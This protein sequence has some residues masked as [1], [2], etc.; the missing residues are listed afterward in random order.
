[1]HACMHAY[2]YAWMHACV[3][4]YMGSNLLA[5]AT[6]IQNTRIVADIPDAEDA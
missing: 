6:D 5:P 2:V 1:M 3:L 4:T